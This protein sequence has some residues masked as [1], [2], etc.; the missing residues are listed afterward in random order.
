MACIFIGISAWADE[1]LLKSS[2]YPPGITTPAGRLKYYSSRFSLAE[3]DSTYHSF[4]TAHNIETWLQNTP[5]GFVF[6]LKAFSLFTLHPT[7]FQSLPRRFREVFGNRIKTKANVYPHHLPEEALDDLWQ[8]YAGIARTFHVAGKLGALLFQF[9]PWFHPAP[10]NYVYIARCRQRLPGFPL[11]V[12]FR[13]GSWLEDEHRKNTL[14]LLRKNGITLVCV[15]GPQG[16]KS[17]MPR[18]AEVTAPLAIV[19]FHGRNQENREKG[20]KQAD[21]MY[22]YLYRTEELYEWVPEIKEMM[23]RVETLHLIFKNKHADYLV[24]NALEMKTLLKLT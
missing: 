14:D 7:P 5:D 1:G 8:G 9:P 2:F 18:P 12:E 20:R 16:L 17:S 4:A 21:D 22:D 10:D 13:D 11:A 6:N 15:D 3:I 19:R 23:N 24:R